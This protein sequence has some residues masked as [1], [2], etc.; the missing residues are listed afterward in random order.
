MTFLKNNKSSFFLLGSM[1]IGAVIGAVWGPGAALLQ[2]LADL[3]LNLLYCVVVPM[4]FISLVSSIANMKSLQK[5]GKVL[6]IMMILF[7]ITQVFA[8]VYMVG[9]CAVFEPGKGAVINM[10]EEVKDMSSSTNILAMFTVNDFSLLWSRKNLMALIVFSMMVGIALL[11]LGEK[12]KNLVA[13]FDE[14]TQLIMKVVGYVM[15]IAP[16]GLGAL[17]ATLVGQYGSEFTGSLAKTLIVYFAAAVAY[18]FI[19]NTLF[20]YIGG[21]TEGVRRYYR[22]CIP[23][24]LTSL[25][26]CSS[27]ASIPVNLTAATKCGIS[28]DVRDLVI[29]LGA[30]LHKDGACLITILKISFMCSVLGINFM[31]PALIFK[32]VVCATLASMVMGAIPAG[33]YVGELFIISMFGFPAVS[34]PVMV[35]IGTITDAPATAIN[36]TGDLSGAMIIERY[37][38]GED[39]L[40]EVPASSEV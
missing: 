10:T 9:V 32:A 23:P 21:G 6:S 25:G 22:Y 18:Y 11:A 1:V 36:V 8:S 3:F 15:K 7:I 20:A 34:I 29:P 14:G 33:G 35:L 31:D 37:T 19:S 13:L 26:T 39:W 40:K 12:G 24:T 27:A 30:N 5:L 38:N 4:I 17:F 16:L 28:N 2:P